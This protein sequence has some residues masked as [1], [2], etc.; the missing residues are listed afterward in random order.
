MLFGNGLL[1]NNIFTWIDLQDLWCLDYA[2]PLKDSIIVE[3]VIGAT[4]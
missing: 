2:I 1:D 4:L 3:I